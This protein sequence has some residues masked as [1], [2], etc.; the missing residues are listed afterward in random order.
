MRDMVLTYVYLCV[1][2]EDGILGSDNPN[3]KL[4]EVPTGT[5]AS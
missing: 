5:E 3:E 2:I 1:E 4:D